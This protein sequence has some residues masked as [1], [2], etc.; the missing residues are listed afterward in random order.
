MMLILAALLNFAISILHVAI[1]VTGPAAY[2]YFGAGSEF[3]SAAADGSLWPHAV[4]LVLAGIF[5]IWGLICLSYAGVL[6][7]LLL[8]EWGVLAI[9][10]VYSV[11]GLAIVAQAVGIVLFDGGD[12]AIGAKDLIL[13]AVALCVGIVHINGWFEGRAKWRQASEKS[14]QP[15][16]EDF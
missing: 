3:A 4:T 13:S 16:Y 10:A 11:R 2:L 14:A 8:V 6:P 15:H 5:S 1:V 9:A 12:G 7:R